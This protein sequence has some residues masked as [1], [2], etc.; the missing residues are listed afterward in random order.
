M[1]NLYLPFFLR[2][3]GMRKSPGGKSILFLAGRRGG[4]KIQDR[5]HHCSYNHNALGVTMVTDCT[6][7]HW[8]TRQCVNLV[9]FDLSY[10]DKTA[11]GIWKVVQHVT[12]PPRNV[13]G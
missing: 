2:I 3:L 7:S 5:I 6:N 10:F 8:N 9:N 4:V 13:V 12:L 11:V 1:E